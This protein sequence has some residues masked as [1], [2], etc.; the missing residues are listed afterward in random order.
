MHSES[1]DLIHHLLEAI[2]AVRPDIV[3]GG[4]P[5]ISKLRAALKPRYG[6]VWEDQPEHEVD[7]A[8]RQGKHTLLKLEANSLVA[9]A[10]SPV[11]ALIE[12]DNYHALKVLNYTHARKVDVIYIDPPYN[13]GTKDFRYNDSFVEKEDGFR[14]SKWLSF[15]SKRLHLAKSLLKDTGVMFIS[16]DENERAALELLCTEEIRLRMLGE[17]IWDKRSQKGGAAAISTS[18]EHVL[19]FANPGFAGFNEVPKPNADAMHVAAKR[20][21]KQHKDLKVAQTEFNAWLR[22]NSI[23]AAEA[24]YN[25]IELTKGKVRLYR[26]TSLAWPQAN[27]NGYRYEIVHPDTK[28]GYPEYA[29]ETLVSPNADFQVKVGFDH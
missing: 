14:H 23:P 25:S 15:M 10:G 1:P 4:Q 28:L 29:V 11:H 6:L 17:L 8:E 2:R 12:G 16:I 13:T 19:V 24:A 3:S 22:Q 9:H 18:H 27:K 20:L 5:D 7:T 26:G 21:V